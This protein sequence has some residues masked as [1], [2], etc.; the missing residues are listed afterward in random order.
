M[1]CDDPTRGKH[2]GS[3]EKD[4]AT[5]RLFTCEAGR[6]SFMK[7]PLLSHGVPMVQALVEKYEGEK[8]D[9]MES[10]GP[11]SGGFREVEVV[12]EDHIRY[13]W[14]RASSAS[15]YRCSDSRE[16]RAQRTRLCGAL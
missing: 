3:V 15:R 5:V 14:P 13:V 8:L 10:V 6:G 9:G 1:E 11:T 4:G 2:D 16:S 7:L 12:G